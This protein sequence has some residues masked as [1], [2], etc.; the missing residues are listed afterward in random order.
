[1]PMDA[2][3]GSS[4]RATHQIEQTTPMARASSTSERNTV[5]VGRARRRTALATLA[6]G[7]AALLVWAAWRVATL[8]ANPIAVL[9]LL[10]EISGW[11]AALLVANGLLKAGAPRRSVPAEHTYRYPTAVADVV[12]RTRASD[13]QRDLRTAIDQLLTRR[14]GTSADRA[15]I[16]VLV[17][18][19]RRIALVAVL[20]AALLVGVPPMPVPPIW[21]L[22]AVAFGSL[23]VACSHVL[24]SGGRIRLGDRMRWSFGALGEVVGRRDH[25]DVAPRRWVG[26]VGSIVVLNVAIALRGMSDRWTHGLPDMADDER[27]V[28]M[29][30]AGL[31]VIGG[32]YALRTI[33]TPQLGNAHVVARR[34]EERTAR[35]SAL[36]GAVCVGLV[37]LVAGVLPGSVDAGPDEPARIESVDQFDTGGGVGD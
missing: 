5:P 29:A 16:G 27:I 21:A 28:T 23:L 15:M 1:M 17:D 19:P 10:I 36:G 6:V 37:G 11:T 9:A 2:H 33:P 26:T 12:G 3:G 18:G 14:S 34:L 24:A 22:V 13:L 25:D 7:T 8:A 31:L 35:Q 20:V 30:W 32:L 4:R